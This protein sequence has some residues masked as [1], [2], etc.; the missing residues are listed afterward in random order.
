MEAVG[1]I[2]SFQ[3]NCSFYWFYV[4]SA[5]GSHNHHILKISTL[6]GSGGKH[7]HLIWFEEENEYHALCAFTGDS[8]GAFPESFK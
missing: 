8:L 4:A 2:S 6:S 1:S 7:H 5:A 3:I